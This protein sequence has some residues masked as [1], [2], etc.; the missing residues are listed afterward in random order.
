M[1]K[2]VWLRIMTI[3]KLFV[4]LY[5]CL[6]L[7]QKNAITEKS[8]LFDKNGQLFVL[9]IIFKHWKWFLMSIIVT[10]W[11]KIATFHRKI[12]AQRSPGCSAH[13]S[14]TSSLWLKQAVTLV[15][16][17]NFLRNVLV[18]SMRLTSHVLVDQIKWRGGSDLARG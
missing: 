10:L 3:V 8:Q 1:Q 13:L 12:S 7:S 6:F 18:I 9:K 4:V 14:Y 5:N 15:H 2:Y 16:L 17:Q 11:Y